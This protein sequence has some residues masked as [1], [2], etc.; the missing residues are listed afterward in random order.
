AAG[1]SRIP[2]GPA[3]PLRSGPKRCQRDDSSD[4]DSDDDEKDAE[5]VGERILGLVQELGF[6]TTL[7]EKGVGRDQLDVICARATG[8]ITK[9]NLQEKSEAEKR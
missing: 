3:V 7:T 9:E 5:K 2:A 8:G 4:D 6:K 1:A